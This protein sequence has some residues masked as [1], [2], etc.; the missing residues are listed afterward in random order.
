M[1][2]D[3]TRDSS[4]DTMTQR[5]ALDCNSTGNELLIRRSRV[6]NPPGSL[7]LR[8]REA[9]GV[10]GI[11]RDSG[12]KAQPFGARRPAETP[13]ISKPSG[14]SGSTI[15]W[16]TLVARRTWNFRAFAT[17]REP[18]AIAKVRARGLKSAG[19][20]EAHLSPRSLVVDQARR[21]VTR[22]PRTSSP[23]PPVWR[24][25]PPR[26]TRERQR[27]RAQYRGMTLGV[28]IV[29]ESAWRTTVRASVGH[30]LTA[31][32]HEWELAHFISQDRGIEVGQAWCEGTAD[33]AAGA[34]AK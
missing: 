12:E 24:E 23:R 14:P 34:P 8:P 30:P 9:S 7:D 21:I 26:T 11:V 17:L 3:A 22:A 5:D 31:L 29:T 2:R 20:H 16:H 10:R 4:P 6:R 15:C 25:A 33:A 27:F 13:A 19:P 18:F 1:L 32:E 28:V